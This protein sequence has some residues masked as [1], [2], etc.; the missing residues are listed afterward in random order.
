MP[1]VSMCLMLKNPDVFVYYENVPLAQQ[2]V[3]CGEINTVVERFSDSQRSIKD[4]EIYVMHQHQ[5][6]IA[7]PDK[8][9][10]VNGVF[11][12]SSRQIYVMDDPDLDSFPHVLAYELG[13]S[14]GFPD[15]QADMN[16]ANAISPLPKDFKYIIK[17]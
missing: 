8:N 1:L 11:W 7:L 6:E 2:K 10:Y 9:I 5:M 4:L 13:H 17:F 3:I 12:N 15:G 16:L 14:I